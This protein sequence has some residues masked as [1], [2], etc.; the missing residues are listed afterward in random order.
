VDRDTL[1]RES[2]IISLHI[3]LLPSTY[4]IINK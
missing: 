2:D 4:H 3:P 1:F